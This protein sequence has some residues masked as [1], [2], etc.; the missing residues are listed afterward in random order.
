[1]KL[2]SRYCGKKDPKISPW[3]PNARLLRDCAIDLDLDLVLDLDLDLDLVL[4]LV[5]DLDLDL[6]QDQDSWLD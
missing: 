2:Q 3:Q 6:D 4:V 1:M 5:L